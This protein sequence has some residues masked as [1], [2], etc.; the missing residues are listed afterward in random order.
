M[1]NDPLG[2]CRHELINLGCHDEVALSQAIDFVRPKRN[3]RFAPSQQ[4][5]RMMSLTFRNLSNTVHKIQSL[6]EIGEGKRAREVVLV[7]HCPLWNLLLD[8]LQFHSLERRD[9]SA[10]GNAVLAGKIF[11]HGYYLFYCGGRMST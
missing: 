1:A 11:W 4:N 2:L 5:V 6:L 9:A 8:A 7:H 3:L 10:A